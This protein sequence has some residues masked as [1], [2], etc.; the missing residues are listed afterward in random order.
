M[1]VEARYYSRMAAGIGRIV[2]APRATGAEETLRRNL[3]RREESFLDTLRRAVFPFPDNPYVEMFRLSGWSYEDLEHHIRKDGLETTLSRLHRDGVYLS[4]DEIKGKTP[5][6]RSGH[7]IPSDLNSFVNPLVTGLYETRSS[8]SRSPGTI[9]RHNLECLLYWEAYDLPLTREFQ[10]HER[11]MVSLSPILPAGWGLG[12]CIQAWRRGQPIE[13]WFS[14]GGTLREAGPY[15]AVTKT[16]VYLA[17][18]LGASVPVPEYLP[19]DDFTPAAEH[20]G[21]LCAEGRQPFVYGVISPAV[22]VASAALEEGIDIRGTIFRAGGEALTD[23][24]R[25][26]FQD[27]GAIIAPFYHINEIGPIG[28]S[29]RE[30]NTGNSVHIFRD[31]LAIVSHRRTA[32]LTEF[33]VDSLLFT[34]LLPF[35]PRVLINVEM[36]DCGKLEPASCDCAYSRLGFNE[37]VSDIFSFGKMTGQGMTVLAGDMLRI[38]EELLPRRFGGVPGDYQLVEVETGRQTQIVLRVSP[39]TKVQ[40]PDEVKG[41][42]L[43]QVKMLYCGALAARNWMQANGLTVL[44]EEPIRTSTGKILPLHLLGVTTNPR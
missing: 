26:V 12:Q 29:C 18:A 25:K 40:T 31:A 4:H 20:L 10:L 41:Y 27:A 28:H 11:A 6:V 37:Q 36:D 33:E 3:S 39:R 34:T 22:R 32:P 5:I 1:W 44:L 23:A 7:T 2:L 42:F 35:A 13:R 14:V 9:T 16:L 30:M 38:L 19:E 8:G 24:K 15:R 43:Q 17:R 21:R